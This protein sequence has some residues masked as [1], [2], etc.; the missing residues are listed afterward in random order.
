MPSSRREP[1]AA[2]EGGVVTV[3]VSVVSMLPDEF[4]SEDSR[5][6]QAWKQPQSNTCRQLTCSPTCEPATNSNAR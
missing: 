3:G 5:R 1:G 4:L 6:L 2:P